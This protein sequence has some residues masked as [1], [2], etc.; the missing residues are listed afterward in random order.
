MEFLWL[1]LVVIVRGVPNNPMP[2]VPEPTVI[3]NERF[4]PQWLE[5]G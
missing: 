2:L 3:G 4:L 1:P 5:M